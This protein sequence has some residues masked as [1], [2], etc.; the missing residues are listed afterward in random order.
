MSG[1]LLGL[2][3]VY[4]LET[5]PRGHELATGAGLQGLLGAL[6]HESLCSPFWDTE[7][8]TSNQEAQRKGVWREGLD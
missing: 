8:V 5:G 2:I 6:P 1:P 4:K 3:N 7:A